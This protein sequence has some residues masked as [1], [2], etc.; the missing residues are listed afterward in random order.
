MISRNQ[1]PK[2]PGA[3]KMTNKTLSLDLKYQKRKRDK[4]D[5]TKQEI[6][7]DSNRNIAVNMLGDEELEKA[8]ISFGEKEAS[9]FYFSF[10]LLTICQNV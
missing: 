6:Y 10:F 9:Y 3:I 4:L 8:L 1:K 7:V 2:L 5:V